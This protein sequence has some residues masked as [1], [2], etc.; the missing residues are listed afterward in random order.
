MQK[1][2]IGALVGGILI[3]IWQFLSWTMMQNHD[4]AMQYTPKQ[5]SILSYLSSQFSSD[6]SYIMPRSAPGTS[7]EECKKQMQDRIGKPTAQVIYHTAMK[8]NMMSNMVWNLLVNIIAVWL[9]C[10]I[11]SGITMNSFGKTFM[12]SLFTGLIIFLQGPYVMHIW[13]GSSDITAH[14]AD[15]LV[16]WGLV[17]LWLGWL[18]NRKKNSTI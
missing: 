6:G 4:K 16:S 2:F 15:Y 14:L 1:T 7:M 12:A 18:L 3:F 10:W 11:L 9:L 8:D 5:D 17:G 13:Y